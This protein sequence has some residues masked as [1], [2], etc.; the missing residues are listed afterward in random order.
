MNEKEKTLG[1]FLTEALEILPKE[2]K[3]FL[4]GYAEGAMAVADKTKEKEAD[5]K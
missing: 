1:E 3:E 2:K 5:Q 4:R